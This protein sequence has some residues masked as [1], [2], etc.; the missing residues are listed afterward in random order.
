MLETPQ[1]VRRKDTRGDE[2]AQIAYEI[3]CEKGFDATSYADI[4]T[5]GQM[6]RSTIYLYYKNKMDVIRAAIREHVRRI[7]A[8]LHVSE[9]EKLPKFSDRLSMVIENINVVNNDKNIARFELALIKIAAENVEIANIWK[10]EV[11]STIHDMC[12]KVCGDVALSD[13]DKKYY[14]T[15]LYATYTCTSVMQLCYGD[16]APTLCFR[17]AMRITCNHIKQDLKETDQK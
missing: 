4:A 2:I 7:G 1:K 15:L 8:N 17:D 11:F 16:D 6:A 12:E 13:Y 9:I 14:L 10:E 3:F 5:R